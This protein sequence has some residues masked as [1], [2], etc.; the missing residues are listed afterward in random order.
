MCNI[1]FLN[2]GALGPIH[3]FFYYVAI[4]TP[5]GVFHVGMCRQYNTNC[6][7]L[8]SIVLDDVI[9]NITWDSIACILYCV[10]LFR[11]IHL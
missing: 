1:S 11:R 5:L 3:L 10:C 2:Q 4:G 8:V 9:E 7:S 6:N